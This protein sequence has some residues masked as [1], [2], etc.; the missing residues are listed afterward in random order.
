MVYFDNSAGWEAVVA[1]FDKTMKSLGYSESMENPDF[2]KHATPEGI[3]L[4]KSLARMYHN[5][6]SV[7]SVTLENAGKSGIEDHR[8]AQFFLRIQE[9]KARPAKR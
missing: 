9:A 1:H 4:A 5:E 7:F 2:T 3:Q 8:P 6:N